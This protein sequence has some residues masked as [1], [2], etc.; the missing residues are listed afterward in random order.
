MED[1]GKVWVQRRENIIEWGVFFKTTGHCFS[2]RKCIYPRRT[3][4][5]EQAPIKTVQWLKARQAGGW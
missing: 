5:N 1:F 3:R 4:I 2:S